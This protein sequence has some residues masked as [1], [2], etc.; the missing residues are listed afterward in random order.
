MKWLC[1]YAG[2]DG[3]ELGARTAP[4]AGQQ[5]QCPKC[6]KR[7]DLKGNP[8]PPSENHRFKAVKTSG[9]G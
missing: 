6:A 4:F 3:A 2:C 7:W 8:I 1:P 9:W 5:R